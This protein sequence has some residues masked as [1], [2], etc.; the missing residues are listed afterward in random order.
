LPTQGAA[1]LKRV[2]PDRWLDRI[3]SRTQ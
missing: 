1:I 2:L 3:M